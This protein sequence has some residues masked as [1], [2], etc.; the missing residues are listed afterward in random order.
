VDDII[1]YGTYRVMDANLAK[2]KIGV[3]RTNQTRLVGERKDGLE[4]Y[5]FVANF[6]NYM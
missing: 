2:V 3:Y 4:G 6:K 1:F 5:I